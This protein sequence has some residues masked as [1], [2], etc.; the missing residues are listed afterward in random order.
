M[1]T[2][3]LRSE[4]RILSHLPRVRALAIWLA[5]KSG[6]N[7]EVDA[8]NSA[9]SVGLVDAAA[10]FDETKGVPFGA[11]VAGRVRGAML[12]LMRAGDHVGRHDRRKQK[13]ACEKERRL[14]SSTAEEP[15]ESAI[16]EARGGT[17]PVLPYR[18]AMVPIDSAGQLAATSNSPLDNTELSEELAQMRGAVARLGERDQLVLSLYY[19]QE[20]TYKEIGVVL[21][22]CESRVCQVLGGIHALLRKRL[23]RA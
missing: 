15:S 3:Q 20:L 8:L 23:V 10:R 2:A 12:D 21:G 11:F 19:E 17:A 9:G 6:G 1:P 4:A 22:V 7:V 5:A 13:V 18:L 14:R 16:L